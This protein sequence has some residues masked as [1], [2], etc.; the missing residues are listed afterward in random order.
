MYRSM[1]SINCDSQS[2]KLISAERVLDP[3]LSW[4]A[5]QQSSKATLGI[6]ILIVLLLNIIIIISTAIKYIYLLLYNCMNDQSTLTPT[7]LKPFWEDCASK[8]PCQGDVYKFTKEANMKV[9]PL[10]HDATR[11]HMQSDW[12]PQYQPHVIQ[13]PDTIQRCDTISTPAWPPVS[14][15]HTNMLLWAELQW[16]EVH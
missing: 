5:C 3:S 16:T 15:K 9:P 4:L 13:Y 14:L 7:Y 8:K 1:R 2:V 11:Y 12:P 6:T 10:S